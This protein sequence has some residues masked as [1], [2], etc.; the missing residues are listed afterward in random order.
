MCL[1]P[2]HT[3]NDLIVLFYYHLVIL[4]TYFFILT[5]EIKI[6]KKEKKIY[7]CVEKYNTISM[8]KIY[9]LIDKLLKIFIK[10]IYI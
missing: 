4:F 3:M 10:V 9:K 6:I 1:S 2:S 7:L 5:F 8:G